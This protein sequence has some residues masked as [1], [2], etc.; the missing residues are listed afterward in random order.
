MPWPNRNDAG[1]LMREGCAMLGTGN[2]G[3]AEALFRQVL[4]ALPNSA[5]AH[6]NL[7][8]ALQETGRSEEA[9]GHLHIA[10]T[11]EPNYGLAHFNLG[12]AL[13]SMSRLKD[14]MQ[15]FSRAVSLMPRDF[16]SHLN[17]AEVLL[18]LRD[19]DIALK[20]ARRAVGLNS[21]K[22][23]AHNVLGLAFLAL[24]RLD[25]ARK[26][27]NRTISLKPNS[28]DAHNNL[29][30]TFKRLNKLEESV[31]H[32]RRALALDPNYAEA[33]LNEALSQLLMGNLRIGWEQHE[34]RWKCKRAQ[35]L[36]FNYSRPLWLGGQDIRGK[37]ILLHAEQGLGDTLQFVRYAPAVAEQGARVLLLVQ[38]SLK[39]LL[40]GVAGVES[41]YASRQALPDFDL[42]CPLMT[43]P[44]AFSTELATIPRTIPYI[45]A[46]ENH[47]AKWREAFSSVEKPKIGIAWSGNPI[48]TDDRNRSLPLSLFRQIFSEVECEFHI[49]QTAINESDSLVLSA[50]AEVVDHRSRIEDFSDTAAV[51]ENLDLIVTVDTSVAHLS[52]A[53]GKP[54]WILLPFSPDWRWLLD[55]TDS[56]WYPTARLYRQGTIGN[57]ESALSRVRADL[58]K[59]VGK[60]LLR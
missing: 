9:R 15:S 55:R 60:R 57:W 14:A 3:D 53:M 54:T 30:T 13:R 45:R 41:T 21:G 20:H 5:E 39:S 7:A 52:G 16:D 58:M 33:H 46:P 42:H 19:P 34:W 32:Y 18:E 49:L 22:S 2:Y 51:V 35:S 59:F 8:A 1:S 10:I 31:T 4:A 27:F 38:P 12:V 11:L 26:C 24:G 28:P 17:L 48:H 29:G 40:S 44:L 25:E 36:E 43:L 56:P 6:C 23:A 47:L 50:T 37:T